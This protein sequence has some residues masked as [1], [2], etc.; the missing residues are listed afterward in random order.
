MTAASVSTSLV[1]MSYEVTITSWLPAAA[2]SAAPVSRLLPWC[3]WTRRLGAKRWISAPHCLTTLI[4][5]TTSVGPTASRPYSSRSDVSIAIAC[6]VLPR[7]MSSARIAPTPRSPSIRSHPWPRSWNGNSSNCIAAGVGRERNRCSSSCR[8]E[9]SGASRV[10]SPSSTPASSVS[11][12]ETA[13]TRST[14]PAPDRRRSRKRSARSTSERRSACHLPATRMKG[15]LA[16]ASSASSSSVST[17][18]PTASRQ[19]NRASSV[20]ERKP[21]AR[22]AGWL[23]AVRLTR[24]RLGERIQAAGSKTGTPCSSS[25]GIA[26][27]RNRRTV[28]GSSCSSAGSAASKSIPTSASTGSSSV[29][30]RIRSRRGSPSLRKAKTPSSPLHSSE[31]GSPSVGSSS[32]C[33]HSS[34]T[35]ASSSRSSR[36]SP[37]LQRV[38]AR[39][40]RPESTQPDSFRSS[41]E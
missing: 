21:L 1:A 33:S 39:R 5:Q 18:S 4:G 12:P 6:T 32:A 20:G 27:R 15:C 26:L 2:T 30:W 28:S 35:S 36:C 13:R 19:S 38:D 23:E 31:A 25:F 37:S 11:R 24:T 9:V 29:S 10:T 34:S 22:R 7:P 17:A 3:M 14:I 41:A 16:A 40:P 8:S